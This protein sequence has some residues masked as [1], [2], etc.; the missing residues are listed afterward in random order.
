MPADRQVL[1]FRKAESGLV[2]P[3]ATLE[4]VTIS[5]QGRPLLDEVTLGL[6]TGGITALLGPNGAGKSLLLRAIAGLIPVDSGEIELAPH[7]GAPALVFQTPVLLNRSAKANL[8]H[9]LRLARVPRRH[10]AGRLAE[11]L[12]TARMTEQ[13]G[14]PARSLS[15]GERQRLA[16]ARALAARP[17]LLLLDEPT[18]HLDPASTAAI[19]ALIRATASSGVK[20]LLV[21]HD[22]AQAARLA[23]DVA[24][25]SRGRITEHRPVEEFLARPE[26]ADARAYLEGRLLL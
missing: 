20:V 13:S 16:I 6:K 17:N 5:R 22:R 24:F 18:A 2:R 21:T 1:P 8:M 9:A 4:G 11:L 12:V 25:L 15:G 7:T 10:R 19:E 14:A 26:S 23:T 3:I